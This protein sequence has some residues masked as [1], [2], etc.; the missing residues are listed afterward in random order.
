LLAD[1]KRSIDIVINGLKGEI[2]VK[3]E[4][5]NGVMPPWS[6]LSDDAIAN[7]LTFVRNSWG[8]TGDAV[9]SAEVADVR[10]HTK[11]PA[12]AAL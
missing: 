7:I 10:A 11:R 5:Y 8:N 9:S 2:A 3:G 12:G 1:K 4:K 6:H